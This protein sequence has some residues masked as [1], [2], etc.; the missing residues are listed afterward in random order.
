MLIKRFN[1][2]LGMTNIHVLRLVYYMLYLGLE[3]D[4]KHHIIL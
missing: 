2:I 1:N 4:T 3:L